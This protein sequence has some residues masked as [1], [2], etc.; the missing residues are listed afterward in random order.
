MA[1][2]LLCHASCNRASEGKMV[3]KPNE[4]SGLTGQWRDTG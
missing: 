2:I 3:R 4:A 1:G